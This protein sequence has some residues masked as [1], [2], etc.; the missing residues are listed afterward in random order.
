MTLRTAIAAVI[1]FGAS[2]AAA[3]EWKAPPEAKAKKNPVAKVAGM[4]EGRAAYET[5]CILCHGKNGRGDGPAAAA[6]SP[7]PRALAD[8]AIQGQT[9]GEIFWKLSEGRGVM[10]PW[11]HL[12][13]NVRWSLVHYIR[14]LGG[15]K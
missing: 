12:P 10:P 9:D 3:Q 14:F 15:K 4:K 5:N 8:K 11:K 6:M 13:E 2:G 1:L 7:K